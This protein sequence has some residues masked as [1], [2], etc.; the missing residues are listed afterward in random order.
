MI[1]N[2]LLPKNCYKVSVDKSLQ[3]AACIPEIGGNGFKTVKEVCGGFV[4]WPKEKVI[5]DDQVHT[6]V[7]YQ[8]IYIYV[9]IISHIQYSI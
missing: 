2:R 7:F 9:Y 5:L 4:A 3:D 8:P 1:H 6:H